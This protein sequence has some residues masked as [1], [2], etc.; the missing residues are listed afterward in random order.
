MRNSYFLAAMF[1][2]G[3]VLCG[4]SR[5]GLVKRGAQLERVGGEFGFTEGPARDL[6]GDIYF[7]D[8][9]QDRI[10]KWSESAGLSVYRD[11]VGKSNGLFFGRGGELLICEQGNRRIASISAD[12]EYRVVA[13]SFDGRRFN[14]PNDLW[15]DSKGGVYFTDPRFGDRGDMEMGVEG[16]YYI[17]AGGEVR[18]VVDDMEGRPNGIFGSADGGHLYVG[19]RGAGKTY[20][21]DIA[22]DGSVCNKRVFANEDSDGMTMDERGNIYITPDDIS[23]YDVAGVKL[24]SIEV[25]EMVTNVCFA[26]AERKTL[27][28]TARNA[29]Y[30]L[31]MN[32][33]GR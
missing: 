30:T 28:I 24:I 3:L 5:D 29:V 10:Y 7:S 4:C 17:G 8:L 13:E 19:D 14:S 23:V 26:G 11:G 18:R 33:R 15:A 2:A 22:A 6:N 21:F 27:F 1:F 9:R 16:V 25:P 20:V 31:E 12:G 32:V